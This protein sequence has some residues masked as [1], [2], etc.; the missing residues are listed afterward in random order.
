[1]DNNNHLVKERNVGIELLRIVSMFMIV[2]LHC[3]GHG[4]IL[5]SLPPPEPF[6]GSS[7]VWFVECACYGAVNLYALITGFVCVKSKWRVSRIFEIWLQVFLYSVLFSVIFK[8]FVPSIRVGNGE[9]L[10]SFFP[11]ISKQ[12]WYF[13]SYFALFFLIPFLNKIVNDISKRTHFALIIGIFILFSAIMPFANYMGGDIFNLNDGYSTMWLIALYIIGA[14]IKLYFDDFSSIKQYKLLIIYLVCAT[15]A[16]FSKSVLIYFDSRVSLDFEINSN[17]F[18]TYN[19]PLIVIGAVCL[20]VF[21]AR[22][23]IKR[24]KKIIFKLSPL[25]FGVYLISEHSCVKQAFI[26][27]HFEPYFD[28][29]WY[30]LLVMA[31]GYALIVYIACSLIDYLRS[32]IFTLFKVRTN[33]DKIIKKFFSVINKTIDK[34]SVN[35]SL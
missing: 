18:I 19:S 21:F 5:D 11:V 29:P 27:K 8:F 28:R 9:F 30:I 24:L 33:C 25:A 12:Y 3:L 16:C 14:Y 32:K 34:K 22:L 6:S 23:N 15:A 35:K 26:L 17:M 10:F 20:F 1:M 13:T 7:A 31:V 2:M 4:G